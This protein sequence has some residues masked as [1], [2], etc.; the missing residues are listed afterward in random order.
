[1]NRHL[2]SFG[3]TAALLLCGQSLWAYDFVADGIYYNITSAENLT[4]AVTYETTDYNSYSGDV[5]IPATVE[6]DSKTYNVTGIGQSAFYWCSGLTSIEIPSGVT[7]IGSEAFDSCTGLTSIE[8]PSS[9]TSIGSGVFANCSGLTS[10][11]IP[12]GLTTLA[13]NAF[14]D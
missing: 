8:L 5:V 13:S 14:T 9:V 6:Y 7:R 10:I 12:D 3:L 11:T 4:V 2:R 1:M